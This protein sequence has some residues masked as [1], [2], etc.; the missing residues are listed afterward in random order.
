M[1]AQP[2]RWICLPMAI[3][4]VAIAASARL[5][6]PSPPVVSSSDGSPPEIDRRHSLRERLQARLEETRE[7]IARYQRH[8]KGILEAIERL[9]G[10][11]S[12]DE[13]LST[14]RERAREEARQTRDHLVRDRAGD[15]PPDR[16]RRPVL[17]PE[18]RDRVFQT[19]KARAP[20]VLERVQTL[21]KQSPEQGDHLLM[22]LAP[23][24]RQIEET[25]RNDAKLATLMIVELQ[26]N[27]ELTVAARDL[28]ALLQRDDASDEEVAQAHERLREAMRR[29]FDAHL[30]IKEHELHRL[31][32]RIDSLRKEV[33]RRQSMRDDY[34][35]R[36]IRKILSPTGD[37]TDLPARGPR[38]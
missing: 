5:V 8:E 36:Q 37:G 10:G 6:P 16:A 26:A 35:E 7:R 29:S 24:I 32:N 9:D 2:M 23:R 21:R 18:A 4:A 27:L 17:D 34:I 38:G 28:R 22:R 31:E 20:R 11:A 1:R 12:P 19:L 30:A 13:V 15:G 25:Q 33:E 14:M 3:G